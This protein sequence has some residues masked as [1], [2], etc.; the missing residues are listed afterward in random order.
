MA[1][2][3]KITGKM[4]VAGVVGPLWFAGWLFTLGF[5]KLGFF[6]GLLAAAI[7]PYYLGVLARASGSG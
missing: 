7:W 1:D 5:V 4:E 6:K 3:Q 2:E